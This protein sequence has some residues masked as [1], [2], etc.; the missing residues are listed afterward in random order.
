MKTCCIDGCVNECEK[1]SRYCR[2]HYLQR[3]RE[4]AKQKYASGFRY[5]YD[6]ICEMCGREFKSG[7][8]TS[9]F[10]SRDCY[11]KY[12]RINSSDATNNYAR[13]HGGGY[14]FAHRRIAETILNRKLGTDEVVHHVDGNPNNNG[15]SNLIVLTRSDHAK[16]HATLT[17]E[18]A[19]L[20][21]NKDMYSENCWNNLIDQITT[22]WLET[23]GVNVIKISDIG[24]PAAK[25]PTA[26][27]EE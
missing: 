8:R 18:R 19:A 12:S 23:T 2:E 13:A 16:L 10:C 24:Q 22:T 21:K 6:R 9:R 20:L 26:T 11:H 25:T 27:T 7:N 15:L 3:K 17:R 1:G 14:S 5:T 4:Q